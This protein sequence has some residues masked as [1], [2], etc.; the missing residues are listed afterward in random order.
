[1]VVVG[2][3]MVVAGGDVEVK[4]AGPIEVTTLD[5]TGTGSL[6][7]ALAAAEAN[8][9]HDT[10][11]FDAALTGVI[12]L[13]ANDGPLTHVGPISI[14]G[15]GSG[16][17]EIRQMAPFPT[18]AGNALDSVMALRG[19]DDDE[20]GTYAYA[21]SVSGLT[22]SGAD[23]NGLLVHR[24]AGA[25]IDDVRVD[26]SGRCGI[27]LRGGDAMVSN[28]SVSDSA[29]GVELGSNTS[30]VMDS[31]FE[32]LSESGISAFTAGSIAVCGVDVSDS[33]IGID[34]GLAGGLLVSDSVLTGNSVAA[35]ELGDG[36]S[37]TVIVENSRLIGNGVGFD[38][39]ES[40]EP[41]VTV[42]D[43][44]ISN[45]SG[46]GIHSA[47]GELTVVRSTIS[48][49]GG[50]SVL[51]EAALNPQSEY[52]T[53]FDPITVSISGS[54]IAGNGRSLRLDGAIDST[55]RNSTISENTTAMT[56][57]LVV[58]SSDVAIE[59]S[60][61]AS[62]SPRP[63]T[64]TIGIDGFSH[65]R[66]DHAIVS[67]N[68]GS[69]TASLSA[70]SLLESDDSLVT[71]AEFAGSSGVVADAP[72]LAA[73]A[74]NG[75][76]TETMLPGDSSPVV[77][78]G[79]DALQGVPELDQRGGDRLIGER[80]DIGAVEIGQ[81]DPAPN[82]GPSD[83]DVG[84]VARRG[85]V[86]RPSLTLTAGWPER[87]LDTRDVSGE[88]MGAPLPAGSVL[89]LDVQDQD[90]YSPWTGVG[91]NVTAVQPASNGFVTVY[92]CGRDRPETSSLNFSAGVNLGNEILAVRDAVGRVCIYVSAS[93][94]LTV[95]K[96]AIVDD[97]SSLNQIVPE[98][99]A[100]TRSGKTT[101][102]GLGLRGRQ[103][104]AGET[105]RLP[106]AGRGS[107]GSDAAT[108]V[109]NITAVRPES[110]GFVTAWACDDERPETSVLNYT[111]GVTRGNEVMVGLSDDGVLCIYSSSATDLTVDVS[112]W[113]APADQI[114]ND[115]AP[116]RLLDTRVNGRSKTRLARV[117]IEGIER[118]DVIA[119]T[120]NVTAVQPE[121]LG[122][123][124]Y[125][126][127]GNT[128]PTTA[129]LN[130]RPGENG[131]NE[132]IVNPQVGTGEFCI[133]SSVPTHLT[134]DLT[135]IITD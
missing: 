23:G 116:V 115:F 126:V 65:V 59:H 28:V 118:L 42:V 86:E 58:R 19:I 79:A 6:T 84:R 49:N 40:A 100:D 114:N 20:F 131:G 14:V 25:E 112:G 94:H 60:T 73:L 17:L 9:G 12:E 113:S 2:G 99:F 31:S 5:A 7:A 93:T 51:A 125:G 111:A 24:V 133:A 37:S 90:G 102:D 36:G 106:T 16:I 122:F 104:S 134:V 61:I 66:L 70:T 8:P 64:A 71:S 81:P 107:L 108:V 89:E 72:G 11:T 30:T 88:S 132:I 74:D 45:S 33:S 85:V 32:R 97:G 128:Q 62:N 48:G 91:L 46:D 22:I 56:P 98:R 43:S 83:C 41:G 27:D 130:F 120:V 75:G 77:D 57:T 13:D 3:Q 123:L 53:F 119:A 82:S 80:V 96:S 38:S 68:S 127:C 92:E 55:I 4:A 76:T 67:G 135:T 1:M 87:L 50:H 26:E 103:L 18:A 78:A 15:P 95:D 39:G 69:H 47:G 21:V 101:V 35:V 129:V 63:G 34:S 29:C 105:I 52:V 44:T 121:G 54:T 110:G 124:T 10:I 117:R 109:A